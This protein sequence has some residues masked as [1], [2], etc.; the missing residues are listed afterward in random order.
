M[1]DGSRNIPFLTARCT[2]ECDD[3]K[4]VPSTRADVCKRFPILAAQAMEVR[5]GKGKHTL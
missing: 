1:E 4:I 3:S 2:A 5:N